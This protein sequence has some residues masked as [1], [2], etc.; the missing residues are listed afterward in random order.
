M[1]ESRFLRHKLFKIIVSMGRLV[2]NPSFVCFLNSYCYLVLPQ[3]VER[4]HNVFIFRSLVGSRGLF[5]YVSSIHSGYWLARQVTE[6]QTSCHI[7]VFCLRRSVWI[8]FL[9]GQTGDRV[10][11]NLS[12]YLILLVALSRAQFSWVLIVTLVCSWNIWELFSSPS[13]DNTHEIS[14]VGSPT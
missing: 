11:D 1:S 5:L 9:V 14:K 13:T 8:N 3:A 6:L 2:S 7:S 10:A 4:L 12:Y